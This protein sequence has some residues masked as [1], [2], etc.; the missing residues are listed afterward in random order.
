MHFSDL[1]LAQ[2]RI[3]QSVRY[4]AVAIFDGTRRSPIE[5]L[6]DQGFARHRIEIIPGRS[7]RQRCYN[8]YVWITPKGSQLFWKRRSLVGISRDPTSNS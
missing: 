2:Q 1:D 6:C 7:P 8:I 3:L 4:G 5:R